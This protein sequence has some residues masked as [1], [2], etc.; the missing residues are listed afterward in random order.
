VRGGENPTPA[1]GEGGA[2]ATASLLAFDRDGALEESADRLTRRTAMSAGA[3]LALGGTGVSA[4]L[5]DEAFALAT[6]SRRRDVDILNF[7]LNLEY[8]EADFYAEGVKRAGLT[9]PVLTLAQIVR[10]HEASHVRFIRRALGPRQYIK[11]P[12]FDFRSTT[13]TPDAFHQTAIK[14]EEAG[15]RAYSGQAPTV[16]SPTI[17]AAAASILTVE[18]R[19]AAAFRQLAGLNPAPNDFDVAASKRATDRAARSLRFGYRPVAFRSS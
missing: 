4:L 5:A 16:R 18:A 12:R 15:V 19:H 6:P 13:A 11:R 10:D 8:L 14:L 3:L 17:L 1:L 7:A 2:T 9:G